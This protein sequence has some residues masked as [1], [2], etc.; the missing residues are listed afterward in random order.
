MELVIIS[1]YNHP[2]F[3]V[4]AKTLH[5]EGIEIILVL[6]E[7]KDKHIRDL[8]PSVGSIYIIENIG[9]PSGVKKL[10]PALENILRKYSS[11]KI[12]FHFFY[13]YSI[14][15][16][17]AE[18]RETYIF[19]HDSVFCPVNTKHLTFPSHRICSI[20]PGFYCSFLP[21][22]C[23]CSGV[24]RRSFESFLRYINFKNLISFFL[25]Y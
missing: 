5:R 3:E 16:K 20:P 4:L 11:A 18:M 13:N 2:Y 22:F 25:F 19:F 12:F 6:G 8:Y 1:Q 7:K 10:P 14:T 9:N 23:G 17:V 24:S 21:Y 15:K